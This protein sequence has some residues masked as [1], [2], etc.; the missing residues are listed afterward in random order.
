VLGISPPRTTIAAS[1]RAE[2]ALQQCIFN[3]LITMNCE[4]GRADGESLETVAQ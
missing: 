4:C 1:R 2:P 3:S